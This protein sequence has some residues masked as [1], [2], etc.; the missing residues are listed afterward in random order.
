MRM[1]G[2]LVFFIFIVL[3]G[4]NSYGQMKEL[5]FHQYQN[6]FEDSLV[7]VQ[8][9]NPNTITL[10]NET[11]KNHFSRTDKVNS[12]SS[13]IEIEVPVDLKRKNF[14]ITVKGLLRVTALDAQDQLVISVSRGDS[15]IFWNGTHLPDSMGKVNQWNNFNVSCLVPR[16]IPKDSKVKIFLWNPDGKSE[17]DLDNIDI[18]FT[19]V[20]FPS[21]LPK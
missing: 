17:T 13:G 4:L 12:Y 3:F 9:M 21:S 10:S 19:E 2:W 14:S 16:N 5:I 1:Q 11:F 7:N 20:E 18:Y 8:W 15:A 6:N